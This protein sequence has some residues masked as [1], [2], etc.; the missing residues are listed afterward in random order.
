ME[1]KT[2]S[3]RRK[4]DLENFGECDDDLFD[5]FRDIPE[6]KDLEEDLLKLNEDS[7]ELSGKSVKAKTE[8]DKI[9]HLFE[10]IDSSEDEDLIELTEEFADIEDEDDGEIIELTTEIEVEPMDKN[11]EVIDLTE[12]ANLNLAED[13]DLIE[14]TEEANL[15]SAKG[16][17]VAERG[18]NAFNI[19]EEALERALEKVIGRIFADNIERILLQAVRKVVNEDIENL[20]KIITEKIGDEVRA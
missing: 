4:L 6:L 5:L 2:E 17:N 7:K 20:K 3:K 15:D 13:D 18:A 10:E 16:E 8:K 19:S 1:K 12:E 9:I 11:N 14:L